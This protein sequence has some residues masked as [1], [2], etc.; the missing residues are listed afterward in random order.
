MNFRHLGPHTKKS[1]P[2]RRKRRGRDSGPFS[3]G[4]WAESPMRPKCFSDTLPTTF[5]IY[6][7]PST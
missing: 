3:G 7:L 2:V 4:S 5:F 1:A 6:S